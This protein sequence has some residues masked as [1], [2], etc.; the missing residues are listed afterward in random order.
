MRKSLHPF[1][2][3]LF[4]LLC[5]YI[6]A[7]FV[8]VRVQTVV[9]VRSRNRCEAGPGYGYLPSELFIPVHFVDRKLL[10]PRMWSFAGTAE[11]YERQ[12]GWLP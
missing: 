12:M 6:I 8:T 7:Y 11:D 2:W 1:A 5:A 9:E 4:A 3:T 10:R